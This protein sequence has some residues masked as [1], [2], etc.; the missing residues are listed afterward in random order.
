MLN[1]FSILFELTGVVVMGSFLCCDCLAIATA[2]FP[3]YI[4]TS[5]DPLMGHS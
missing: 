5:I 2:W 4:A 1:I 3:L